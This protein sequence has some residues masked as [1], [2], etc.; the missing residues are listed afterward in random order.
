MFED[1]NNSM[2]NSSDT[3]EEAAQTENVQ[4]EQFSDKSFS[5]DVNVPEEPKKKKKI[6]VKAVAICALCGVVFGATSALTNGLINDRR[7]VTTTSQ[8]LYVSKADGSEAPTATVEQIVESCLPSVVSITNKGV[9][10]V[11]T[12]FGTFQQESVSTGT[13]IIVGKNDDELLIV[14][15]YHVIA[16]SRELTVVFAHD[17]TLEED[18]NNTSYMNSAQV[19]GYDADKDIAVVA[20]PLKEIKDETMENIAI[21][22]LGDSN[23]IKMGTE[24]VAIGNALGYGQSV[25]NGIIS[26]LDRSITMQNANGATVTNKFIQTNA[27]INAGNSGGALLNM[28]GEVIGINSAKIESTGVE[29]MGYAIPISDVEELI[30]NLMTMKTR[31]EVDEADRGYIGIKGAD[32]T[33]SVSKMYG[34]PVGVFVSEIT[35]DSPAEKAGLKEK[36][37]IVKFDST[38]VSSM[39]DLQGRL[40]YYKKGEKVTITVQR[41]NGNDFEE[42]EL[43]ITLGSKESAGI[44]E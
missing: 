12:F 25:T 40:A 29:G 17:A 38:T 20:V 43:E 28:A 42:L 31:T 34:M 15:N 7:S 3:T 22:T 44:D 9:S 23:S 30:E 41:P 39:S 6:G 35:K 1:T 19:K 24:V 26:A 14:T 4:Q 32:V 21:A 10:E 18:S 13:G 2:E 11:S 36:D 16:D 5:Y 37:V 33:S 27:A 8:N